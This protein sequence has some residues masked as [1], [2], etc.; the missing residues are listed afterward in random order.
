[1]V[2]RCASGAYNGAAPI[3]PVDDSAKAVH[4]LART[5]MGKLDFQ[6]I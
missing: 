4:P 3:A 2:L 1:M 6:D 5:H